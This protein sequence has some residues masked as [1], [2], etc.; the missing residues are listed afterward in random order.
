MNPM[1]PVGLLDIGID[2]FRY[3]HLLSQMVVNAMA[4][5]TSRTHRIYC[6]LR[7]GH[8]N[9]MDSLILCRRSI[10]AWTKL[11]F[12]AW[13]YQ[14]QTI[15]FILWLYLQLMLFFTV[16]GLQFL[17]QMDSGYQR[18]L[19]IHSFIICNNIL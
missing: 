9:V 1:V 17:R 6:E 13:K 4:S 2:L 18:V 11:L 10:Q 7:D 3:R 15:I 12:N 14:I 16:L 5:L 19:T 8:S